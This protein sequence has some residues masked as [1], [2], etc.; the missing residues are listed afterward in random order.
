[1]LRIHGRLATW[2]GWLVWLFL[3]WTYRLGSGISAQPGEEHRKH[4]AAVTAAVISN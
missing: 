4:L 1:M 2:C 3:G